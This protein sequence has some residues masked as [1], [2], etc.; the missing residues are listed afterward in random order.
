VNSSTISCA[1]LSSL[2]WLTSQVNRPAFSEPSTFSRARNPYTLL[3]FRFIELDERFIVSNEVGEFELLTAPELRALLHH[4]LDPESSTFENLKAK[5]FLIDTRSDVAIKQLAIKYRT[6]RNFLRGFTRL[7]IFVVTLRCDTSCRY[8]QVSRVSA[9]H[10]KYD[11]SEE[12]ASRSLDLVFRSPS[13]AIKIEFQG[14]EP[15][16]NFGL[17]KFITE[18]AKRRN[19]TAGKSIDFV[20]T[21]NLSL[22]TDEM[23]A[24]LKEH[25]IWVSTS[26]DGPAF[27]HNAN[28]PRPG[29]DAYEKTVAGIVQVRNTLGEDAVSALMTT[30]R[31]SLDHPVEIVD[32]YLAQGFNHIFLRPLSPYGFAMKTR[33]KTGYETE[34]FLSFYK[35]ALDYIIGL[36][37]EGQWMVEIYAQILLRKILTPFAT[38]YVDLQSPAGA[39]IAVAVY[40]YDGDVYASDESRMLAEM[41]DKTFRLGNVHSD[42]YESIFG[43]P[44]IRTLVEASCVES[45]PGCADCALQCY[46]GA[47]P[48][49]NFA[50]QGD[51]IGHRPTSSFCARN[52][53]IIKHLIRLYEGPDPFVRRLF[54]SWVHNVPVNGLVPILPEG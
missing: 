41:G 4:S 25:S 11:M 12:S 5:H 21:T 14:G 28:R 8:C 2:D 40:N 1:P 48:V 52:M 34:H 13:N 19:A 37:R 7:H 54:W 35:K 32:E 15:L 44:L 23:L 51:V 53:E 30:T 31:L 24:Y 26:L 50:T 36:N 27:I 16:L 49:E 9:D 33:A 43:G 17:I 3:P 46:C 18:E 42:S 38:G 45:L 10:S 29:N 6:K 20:V 47:D 39:G 22:V